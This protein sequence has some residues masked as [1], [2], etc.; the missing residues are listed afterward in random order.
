MPS[1]E[2]GGVEKNLFIITNFLTKKFSNIALITA[3]KKFNSKFYKSVK[4]INP[5][6]GLWDKMNRRFKYLVSIYLL[7]KEILRDKNSVVFSF[8]ANIYCIIICRIFN[9]K[10]ISRSNTATVGWSKNI[11][12]RLIFSFILKLSNK[13]IVN[14]QEFKKDLKKELGVNSICI[15][16]PLNSKEILK[17]SKE[18]SIKIFKDK[19]KLN[20]LNIGRMT[21]Q[22]D[23]ITLLKAL[24][25]I[26][27]KIDFNAVIIGRGILKDYLNKYIKRKNLIKNIKILNF[28]ENPFPLIKQADLF[29]LTSKFEGLPNVLLESLSL[30]KFIIS[31]N[32]PTGPK[33]I[34]LNGKGGLL[35]EVGNYTQLAKKILFYQKNKNRSKKMINLAIKKIHRF[36]FKKNLDEYSKLI[37]SV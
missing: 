18:N 32:C 1:I 14:S 10:V 7:I 24:N 28:V 6:S 29:V 15:Y 4:L 21:D 2:G 8:Q 5:K 13:I 19:K 12:K 16:N 30:K 22:K 20:I 11:F 9:I 27:D 34:L 3:S 17:K 33:E 36:D 23:Q 37:N 35:F 31:S 26:K 25:E